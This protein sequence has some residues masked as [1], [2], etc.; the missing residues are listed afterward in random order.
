LVADNE[1]ELFKDMSES[2]YETYKVACENEVKITDDV[3]SII[4]KNGGNLKGLEHRIKLPDSFIRKV[5]TDVLEKGISE[6]ES[7]NDIRDIIR[8]TSV[9][10][11]HNIINSC[12]N[13]LK[14]LNEKGYNVL[15]VKNTWFD[16]KNPYKGINISI[17]SP[18]K[19]KFEVQF[20]TPQSLEAKGKMHILYKEARLPTTILSI[21]EKLTKEMNEISK[22]LNRPKNIEK[23]DNIQI[24]ALLNKTTKNKELPLEYN[25]N[26]YFEESIKD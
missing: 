16:E 22:S 18:D 12:L 21:K 6:K 1:K 5:K 20:H 10:N 2:T 11:S 8:Y 7:V 9:S 23:I 19:Q 3:K 25:L 24:K 14:E 4:E 13:T 26:K 15:I 17:E